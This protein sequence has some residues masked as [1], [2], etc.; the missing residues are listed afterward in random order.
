MSTSTS[1]STIEERLEKACNG[2]S[3]SAKGM[4]LPEL[5]QTLKNMFPN[6]ADLIQNTYLRFDLETLGKKLLSSSYRSPAKPSSAKPSPAKPSPAK[7]SSEKPSPA[8][9][10]PAKPSPAKPSS[11][12]PS[13]AKPSSAKPSPLRTLE[14]TDSSRAIKY[15]PV[16]VKKDGRLS[17]RFYYDNFGKDKTIGDRCDIRQD[18]TYK[19]LLMTSGDSPRWES[20]T[21]NFEKQQPCGDFSSKCKDPEF[22]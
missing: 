10:S 19:C 6:K 22:A 5:R 18:G 14:P 12:K 21:K 11:A 2:S 3:A 17:A 1:T 9:P 13:P 15:Q 7:P 20:K 4:N 16:K 8:K